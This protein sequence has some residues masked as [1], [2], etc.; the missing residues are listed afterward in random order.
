MI[1]TQFL[2]MQAVWCVFDANIPEGL[3]Y[4]ELDIK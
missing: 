4:H 2:K 3:D 1:K